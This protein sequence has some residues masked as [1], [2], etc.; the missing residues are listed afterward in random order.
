M[1]GDTANIPANATGAPT[2]TVPLR[3]PS[4]QQAAS[5]TTNNFLPYALLGLGILYFVWA[6]L[7][8]RESVRNAIKPQN[9]RVNVL[10]LLKVVLMVVVGLGFLKLGLAKLAAWHVPGAAFTLRLISVA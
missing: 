4:S 10:N 3:S 9:I 6:W 5:S 8:E 1:R 7:E 2:A